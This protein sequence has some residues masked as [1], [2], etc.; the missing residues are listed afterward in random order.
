MPTPPCPPF[1]G[2]GIYLDEEGIELMLE[3]ETFLVPTL[4]APRAVLAA[5]ERG[6]PVPEWALEKTRRVIDVD[7]ENVA[8]AHRAGARCAL[9]TD[10]GVS[11][12]GQNLAELA[13]LQEIGVS[14]MDAIV[15][16]TRRGAEVMGLEGDLGTIKE[17][18]LADLVL[19]D[20][21][22][23]ASLAS[24]SD[25]TRIRVVIQDGRVVKNLRG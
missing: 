21:D 6:L 2:H 9:G 18:K 19:T 13:L 22:P 3:H 7:Q 8:R 14:P 16:G 15:A 5:H 4:V 23:R 10:S 25:P 24:L 12:H 1:S 11:L 17:G 20:V